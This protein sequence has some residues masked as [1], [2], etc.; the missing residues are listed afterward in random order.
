MNLWVTVSCLP[1]LQSITGSAVATSVVV[2]TGCFAMLCVSDLTAGL[3][4]NHHH[5]RGGPLYHTGHLLCR[6]KQ[7]LQVQLNIWSICNKVSDIREM[8]GSKRGCCNT[9]V[10]SC[11]L[12]DHFRP[13]LASL[14]HFGSLL[15][16]VGRAV[17]SYVC[18][19]VMHNIVSRSDSLITRVTGVVVCTQTQISALCY[20][21]I[22]L[23][24]SF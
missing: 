23:Q 6:L 17:I 7:M 15:T 24:R 13:K 9:M 16:N 10:C 3:S 2:Y 18:V 11:S 21:C 12:S 14:A 20:A 1:D 5:N 22:F 4:W 19:I 8:S